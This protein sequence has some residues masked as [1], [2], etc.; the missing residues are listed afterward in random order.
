MHYLGGKSRISKDIAKILNPATQ[1]R[2]FYD[3]FCGA[4]NISDKIATAKT[5]TCSDNNPYLIALF[6]A[7]QDGWEPPTNVSE[8]QY[9][10][11]C[12]HPD[13]QPA[14]TAFILIGCSFCGGW[15]S[16]FARSRKTVRNYAREA[17]NSL[18]KQRGRLTS[19]SFVC[20]DYDKL[21]IPEG[22]VVYC[23]PPYKGTSLHYYHNCFDYDRFLQWIEA[24]KHKYDIYISEYSRNQVPGFDIV[25]EKESIK[26]MRNKEGICEPTHEV[27]LHAV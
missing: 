4:C 26:G 3:V 17:A 25:W 21:A 5:R 19:V 11:V 10:W 16:G 20:S 13:E 8:D 1:G 24:N 12:E 2:D 15:K 27:L 6:K 23:D 18:L 14:L 22:S 7:I 9:K